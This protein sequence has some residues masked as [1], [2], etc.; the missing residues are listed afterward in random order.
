MKR[1]FGTDNAKPC[2]K[3]SGTVAE[4]TLDSEVSL[5][6]VLCLGC[7]HRDVFQPADAKAPLTT[8][9]EVSAAHR[10]GLLRFSVWYMRPEWFR[11]GIM[12]HGFLEMRGK[13]PT[14]ATLEASH[15]LLK[16]AYAADLDDLFARM[17]GEHWSPNG[18]AREL[19]RARGLQ[20]TSMS[21]GDI[22]IDPAGKAWIVDRFGFVELTR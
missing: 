12:G 7:H 4:Y 16:Y 13:L 2:W 18:E 1:I 8:A 11:D 19:I 15:V 9:A 6:D 21:V 22:A 20:H 10:G 3:C 17:Q 14:P 5:I